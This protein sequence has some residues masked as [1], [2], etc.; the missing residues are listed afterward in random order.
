MKLVP[1]APAANQG[2]VAGLVP[3]ELDAART[4]LI[5][6][7]TGPV[8]RERL[9]PQLRTV[10]FVAADEQRLALVTT[11]FSGWIEKLLVA[12]S[13][14]RVEKGQI[15]ATAYSQELVTAQQVYLNSVKWADKQGLAT[16]GGAAGGVEYDARRRLELLG[17]APQDVAEIARTGQP[18]ATVPVRSPVAGY[19]ARKA[20]L[21]GLYVQP[22]TELFQIVDLSTVW[23]VADVYERDVDRVRVGQRARFTVAAR[24]GETFGGR[25]QF[26]YPAVNPESRTVQA[27]IE[28]KNPGLRLKP[29]MYG[30]VLLDL[31]AGDALTVPGEAVV[32]TGDQ[33]YVFVARPAGRFEPRRVRLGAGGDGRVQVLEGLAEGE[34]V[35]TTANF[36]V[37][38]ESRLRAA[39]EGF[40]PVGAEDERRERE[41]DDRREHA[42]ADARN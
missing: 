21:P 36:L 33:Q 26:V 2:G 10:G 20:A 31:P 42:R 27:R 38:S 28:L 7:R 37:D 30:D 32:D 19:V 18:L 5:G 8:L 34:M 11:R 13:G 15:L 40:R 22:G 6:M 12:Q 24:Q 3:V 17:V 16:A 9:A 23:V 14:A 4:Q 29:G 25:V 41:G 1:R 35:V 39:V